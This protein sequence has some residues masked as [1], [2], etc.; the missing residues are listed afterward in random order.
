MNVRECRKRMFT[1]AASPP[2]TCTLHRMEIKK[3]ETSEFVRVLSDLRPSVTGIPPKGDG[4]TSVADTV[5]LRF[6]VSLQH[7]P[8]HLSRK[9]L[10]RGIRGIDHE[11]GLGLLPARPAAGTVAAG[12]RS[13][14]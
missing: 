5:A 10:R 8:Q 14:P 4:R 2:I 1:M 6:P 7:R 13:R 12:A 9:R 11:N 3:S